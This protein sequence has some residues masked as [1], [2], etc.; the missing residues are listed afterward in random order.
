M[1]YTR[2]N[3]DLAFKNPMP[4]VVKNKLNEL[5]VM[6]KQGQVY[7]EKINEGLP[8]EENTVKASYHICYHDE[9]NPTPCVEIE[10]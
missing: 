4:T 8:N 10:I 7:A 3:I 5:K 1:S 2:I 9:P 6:V